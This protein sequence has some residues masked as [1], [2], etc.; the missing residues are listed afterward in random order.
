MYNIWKAEDQEEEKGEEE[1]EVFHEETKRLRWR[2]TS[3]E[4]ASSSR[5][6]PS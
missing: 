2:V 3:C 6:G 5:R 1:E 4:Q